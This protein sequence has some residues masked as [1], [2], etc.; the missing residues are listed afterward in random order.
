M[1]KDGVLMIKRFPLMNTIFMRLVISFVLV[2][3]PLI[4]L[5]FTI[6]NW[7]L[8]AI[9]SEIANSNRVQLEYYRDTLE[10]EFDRIRVLAAGISTDDNLAKL[11]IRSQ[12]IG[13][14]ETDMTL[15]SLQQRCDAVKN[16]SRY[17]QDVSVLISTINRK[18][19]STSIWQLD[20]NDKRLVEA[21]AVQPTGV[22]FEFKEIPYIYFMLS[23]TLSNNITA[24]SYVVVSFSDNELKTVLDDLL[25][26]EGSGAFLYDMNNQLLISK[27]ADSKIVPAIC[28][29]ISGQIMASS[30]HSVDSSGISIIQFNSKAYSVQYSLIS[31]QNLLL[32][33]YTPEDLVMER[34]NQYRLLF[35][36][37]SATA[38][39][40]II[41][42]SYSTYR[43]IYRPLNA[44]SNGFL[45]LE[46]GDMGIQ[47][48][49][50]QKDEFAS[51]FQRFNLM[52]KNLSTL[53]DQVFKA[54]IMM[55][56]AEMKQLQAQINPHFLYNSFF[57]LSR[58]IKAGDMENASRFSDQLGEYFQFIT[59]ST[60]DEVPLSQEVAHARLYSEIQG[61]RF[62]KRIKILFGD[63]PDDMGGIL[64]PRLILQPLI[65]NSF[66]HSLENIEENGILS[67]SFDSAQI[68]AYISVEDNGN[69]LTDETLDKL[70]KLL[71]SS[72]DT[73]EVTG[74]INIHKRLQ[75]KF[76]NRSG[77]AVSRS[78]FGGLQV[79]A[80]I[81]KEK[82]GL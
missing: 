7:G 36:T 17:I 69:D 51:I 6:Y 23:T 81:I 78:K 74:M 50:R 16:S 21:F 49:H 62:A 4:A 75:L 15:L 1:H 38:I 8:S 77:L 72:N 26:Y 12:F 48:V 39:I 32:V 34:I 2:I 64:V 42:F 31:Q 5:G 41:I 37:F 33:R 14:Y 57:I 61:I 67:V 79:T 82:E 76:G 18:I 66:E 68:A 56:H 59:R 52:V 27:N 55:Q 60:K 58:R 25:S 19:T 3:M 28:R 73:I 46:K 9:H 10:K 30:N 47:I 20:E 63:M 22:L 80:T 40:I 13:N 35:A 11:T 53:I 71:S 44:L 65:E 54:K 29:S 70:G 45:R 43:F 24:A